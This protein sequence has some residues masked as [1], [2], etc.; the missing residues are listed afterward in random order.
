MTPA[1]IIRQTR[2][3]H[4]R[5]MQTFQINGKKIKTNLG[6]WQDSMWNGNDIPMKYTWYSGGTHRPLGFGESMDE[7]FI[8]A[9]DE[10]W[11]EIRFVETSTMVRGYHHV[12]VWCAGKEA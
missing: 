12:Y 6:A 1:E 11:T 3:V 9:V 10:G 7:A 2:D 5:P 4:G 8:K